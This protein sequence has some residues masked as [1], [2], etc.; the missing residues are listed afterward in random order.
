[1]TPVSATRL[2]SPPNFASVHEGT[3]TNVETTI[4]QAPIAHQPRGQRNS[5]AAAVRKQSGEKPYGSE[6]WRDRLRQLRQV[7][8]PER[9]RKAEH[10]NEAVH[11]QHDRKDD[12]HERSRG[13]R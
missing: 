5:A 10:M 8:Q 2:P 7:G 1:M 9:F 4:A 12:G 6:P 3:M 11:D 13:L